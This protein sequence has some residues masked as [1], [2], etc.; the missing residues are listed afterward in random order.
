MATRSYKVTKFSTLDC[1]IGKA[2]V[3]ALQNKNRMAQLQ[4]DR[5]K[6]KLEQQEAN[7]DDF[8]AECKVVETSLI[9]RISELEHMATTIQSNMIYNS[10]LQ[11]RLRNIL[12]NREATS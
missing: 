7:T 10:Y 1:K 9:Q 4:V 3:A 12:L 11:S 2:K 5:L 8:S 6:S